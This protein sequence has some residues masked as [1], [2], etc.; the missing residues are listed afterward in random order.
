MRRYRAVPGVIFA[1][2]VARRSRWWAI[3]YAFAIGIG[4]LASPV[5]QALGVG[6]FGKD[7]GWHFAATVLL[8]HLAFGVALGGVF[9]ALRDR[10]DSAGLGGSCSHCRAA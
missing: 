9:G 6:L 2:L 1:V 5:V 3:P 4:F 7:F 10:S 8:A